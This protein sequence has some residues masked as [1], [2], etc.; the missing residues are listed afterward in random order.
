MRFPLSKLLLLAASLAG[1]LH[2]ENTP[3]FWSWAEKPVMG[4]NSWDF[5]G[6]SI[7]EA[8]SKAQADYMAANLLSHG[9]NL[10]TVDIQ[11]YEPN[12]T[13]FNYNAN[14]TLTM[15][16]LGRLTPAT[17]RFPSA[18]G[19]AGFK[20]LA[21][22]IHSKGLKF[23]IHMMRGIPR[24]AW[25]QDLPVKGTTY[26]AKDIA[27][28][29][30]TCPWNPDMYGVDMN[31]PGAQAYYDSIM[32][33]VAS[34][35]VDFVKIDDL[36]RPYHLKE[37]E[38]IRKAIDKTGRAIVFST[39]PGETPV[40]NGEH[41]MAHANQWRISDD[42]WD[43][44]TPLYEQFK[45][46]HDWTPYRGP[47]HFP[48]ADMLPLGKLQGGNNTATGR[49]TNFTANEQTTMMSLWAIARSPLIHGGDMTQ[50]D[51]STLAL[52]T[53]D[54][55]IALNQHSTHNRQLFRS[56]DLIAWVADAENSPDKYLAV[57]NTGSA[58]ANVPV[59]LSTLGFSGPVQVR[60]LWDQSNLG[61][62]SG[63]FSPSIASH[64]AAL[65][66][67]VGTALPTPWI[68]GAAA[69]EGQVALT[70][71][72]LAPATS[73]RLKRG[74][75]ESGPFTVIADSLT[76]TAFIDT[77]VQ[78]GTT[79]FYVVSAIVSGQETPDSGA[80]SA[81]PAGAPQTVSWNYD[82]F[83]TVSGTAVAGVVPVANWNNSYPNNPVIDLIDSSG[84]ATTLDIS[85]SS[86][87]NWSIQGSTPALD[88]NGASN[89]RLLN[90]YL[91]AGPA[92]WNPSTIQTSVG[93]SQIPHG[94]YDLIVYFSSDQ[95]GREGQVTDGTTIYQFS[96]LGPASVTGSNASLVQTTQTATWP[97]ANY[98]VF[99]GLRGDSQTVTVKMRDNDEWGGIA[100]VQVVP[101]TDPLPTTRLRIDL[102][103]VGTAMLSWPAIPGAVLL[104]ESDDLVDWLPADPQPVTNSIVVAVDSDRRFYRLARP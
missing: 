53:N 40:G 23:G 89:K 9:W 76:D 7:N 86:Y 43:S 48:D 65:Y 80:R 5:Y 41:V 92:A 81:T 52:L 2:A 35:E 100:A 19:G 50:M 24:Q 30:S 85:Y 75:S 51:A 55:V 42:F 60:S 103:S 37:I 27:D 22:Y 91:N 3:A 79:Y 38:G 83:G 47:G 88:G 84:I 20:P 101:Q 104:Q 56:G 49:V 36:S 69:T 6:T 63:S 77:T 1:A 14:A 25:Q 73:Y 17:N 45:R 71:E 10:I 62:F 34:W 11:W 12:A 72:T 82:R 57:F 26:T 67:L 4:W 87:N 68:I 28:P 96:S 95:A 74:I 90:G 64:G 18:A 59:A 54:E 93:L 70:W 97:G 99:S 94:Y 13:G 21:D 33:M 98:A 66:R 16:Q 31:K 58:T 46:L 39:S 8:K 61:G 102:Q 78:N 44:W 29:N 15:D 32:E